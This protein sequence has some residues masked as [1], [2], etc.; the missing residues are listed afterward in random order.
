MKG[1]VRAPVATKFVIKLNT[2]NAPTTSPYG[3]WH[4]SCEHSLC[5]IGHFYWPVVSRCPNECHNEPQQGMRAWEIG[6]LLTCHSQQLL[7]KNVVL[8][9]NLLQHTMYSWVHGSIWQTWQ[10]THISHTV[11]LASAYSARS[12]HSLPRAKFS[13][14]KQQIE[15]M[16][17]V[18]QQPQPF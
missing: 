12:T 7:N 1:A 5:Q 15:F 16:W 6:R 17:H 11:E 10:N 9:A 2:A 13:I 18:Q 4:S 14:L 3:A 8:F